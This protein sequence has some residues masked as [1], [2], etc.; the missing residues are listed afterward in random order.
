MPSLR[1]RPSEA[2]AGMSIIDD[3]ALEG[4]GMEWDAIK[5]Q[6]AALLRL[7]DEARAVGDRVL[8]IALSEKERGLN[9]DLVDLIN[10]AERLKS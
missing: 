2:G 5:R 6:Q 1:R 7:L 3:F 4:L 10:A 8:A 9:C